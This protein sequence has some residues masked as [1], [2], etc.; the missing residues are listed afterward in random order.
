VLGAPAIGDQVLLAA[1]PA[2]LLGEAGAPSRLAVPARLPGFC[3]Q[4]QGQQRRVGQ[5]AGQRDRLPGGLG[6]AGV[7]LAGQL[8][9]QGA[10]QPAAGRRVQ[11]GAAQQP[12]ERPDG[13]LVDQPVGPRHP[14]R[15]VGPGGEGA[16]EQVLAAGR[17]GQVDGAL[18]GGPGGRDRPGPHLRPQQPAEEVDLLGGAVGLALAI[19]VVAGGDPLLA[20][21]GLG[22]QLDGG[23]VGVAAL[24]QLGRARTA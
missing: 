24:G 11:V 7:A 18:T 14:R 2:D 9:G 19:R 23:V 1:D 6:G 10:Q 8:E 5:V 20:V 13:S 21:E 16:D 15:R 4:R 17:F 22:E 12:Q 3:E